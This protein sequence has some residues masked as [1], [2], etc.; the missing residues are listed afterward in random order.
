MHTQPISNV[1][2]I[3]QKSAKQVK[4]PVC[5]QPLLVLSAAEVRQQLLMQLQSSLD[6]RTVLTLFFNTVTTSCCF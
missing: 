6:L 3:D 2:Y 5:P 4:E 1:I